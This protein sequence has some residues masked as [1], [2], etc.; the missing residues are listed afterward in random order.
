MSSAIVPSGS[1]EAPQEWSDVLEA[2]SLSLPEEAYHGKI[3]RAVEYLVNGWPIGKIA[4]EIGVPKD[5]IRGWLNKY[6][7]TTLAVAQGKKMLS[8]Y[9]MSR[10]QQQFIKAVERSEEILD[11]SL[12]QDDSIDQKMV[13]TVAQH[14]RFVIGLFAGQQTDVNIKVDEGTATLLKARNEALDYLAQQLQAQRDSSDEE[15]IEGIVRIIDAQAPSGPLLNADGQPH[16]GILGEIDVDDDGAMCH[17]CGERFRQL[18]LHI[19]TGEKM[20]VSEYETAFLLE[21]GAVSATSR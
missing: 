3:I 21:H 15:P 16:H 11:V 7:Q 6:P 18:A 4:K 9:R 19:R 20:S 14:A 17:I 5:T 2:L 13:A 1:E 12:K 8:Q 10:L